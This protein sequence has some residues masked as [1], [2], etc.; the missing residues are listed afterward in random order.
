MITEFIR[1]TSPQESLEAIQ[2]AGDGTV[3]LA[4]GTE[5]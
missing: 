3:F 1:A 4:G 5:I 2:K